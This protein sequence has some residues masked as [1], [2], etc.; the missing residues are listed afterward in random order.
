MNRWFVAFENGFRMSYTIDWWS[1]LV[2]RSGH[3]CFWHL[4]VRLF[5][6]IRA[7]TSFRASIE[8]KNNGK[9]SAIYKE[10]Q[11]AL[12]NDQQFCRLCLSKRYW[13]THKFCHLW[14]K[15]HVVSFLNYTF[16]NFL[17]TL[18]LGLKDWNWGCWWYYIWPL[19]PFL[20]S[21]S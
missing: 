15:L 18:C 21:S 13:S 19:N 4:L 5:F 12:T 2:S 6:H 14:S 8:G 20:N 17:P 1:A 3:L 7:T 9:N 10:Y 11:S 16:F